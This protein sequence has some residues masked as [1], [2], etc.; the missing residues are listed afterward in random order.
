LSFGFGNSEFGD[1]ELGG[2][3]RMLKPNGVDQILFSIKRTIPSIKKVLRLI[4]D[5]LINFIF[6]LLK[7]EMD[8]VATKGKLA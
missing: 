1:Q 8:K 6:D 5:L 7:A 3:A 4:F 2:A